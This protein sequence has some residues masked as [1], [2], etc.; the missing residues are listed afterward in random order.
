MGRKRGECVLGESE[1]EWGK[2]SGMCVWVT[3]VIVIL[4]VIVVVVVV[5][6]SGKRKAVG[7]VKGKKVM[8]LCVCW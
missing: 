1:G 3:M 4:V 8:V 6:M 7:G 5:R 2:A